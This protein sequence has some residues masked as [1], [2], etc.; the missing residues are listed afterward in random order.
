MLAA[1]PVMAGFEVDPTQTVR[2]PAAAS[3]TP[4]ELL[5][6]L[7]SFELSTPAQRTARAADAGAPGTSD[8]APPALTPPAAAPAL[9]DLDQH[10]ADAR[11]ARQTGQLGVARG[12]LRAA[13]TLDP[14]RPDVLHS[15]AMTE[16]Y[17]KN[18]SE[19][20]DL[21]DVAQ[22]LVPGDV[23]IVLDRARVMAWSGHVAEAATVVDG[24]LAEHDADAEAWDLR[25]RLHWYLAQPIA[26]EAAARR[27][28]GLDPLS[29]DFKLTLAEALAA[30]GQFIAAADLAREV[31]PER[32]GDAEVAD[33]LKSEYD[34][35]IRPWRV[36]LSLSHSSIERIPLQDWQG[37]SLQVNRR[38]SAT[39]T[40][41]GRIDTAHRFAAS[42]T[43][44]TGGLAHTFRPGWGG[45][46]EATVTPGATF[47][48]TWRIASG[49]EFRLRPDQAQPGATFLSMDG[50]VAHYN[51][52]TSYGLAPGVIQYFDSGQG[53]LSVHL[54]NGIDTQGH[55]LNGWGFRVDHLIGP[56]WQAHASWSRSPETEIEANRGLFALVRA[57]SLGGSWQCN[58]DLL[59][60]LDYVRED[61]S[62][63]YIRHELLLGASYRF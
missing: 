61:R 19:A 27:A 36:D 18:Y 26:A 31:A 20:L 8:D 55:Y 44:L 39:D 15:L 5:K 46:L 52:G 50:A 40:V 58:P 33:L 62:N 23:D 53:W 41:Y 42:D 59:L 14:L 32:P 47:F 38:L 43:S 3:D 34:N 7:L 9:S 13:L 51:T 12:H 30:Q 4:G 57:L 10:L 35:R 6:L 11:S 24:V 37:L 25:A 16:A 1:R 29:A 21:L 60:R 22:A 2:E 17:D 54:H 48:P 49:T 45:F 63:S 56:D 28:V